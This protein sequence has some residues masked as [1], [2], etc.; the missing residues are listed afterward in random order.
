MKWG[1]KNI[2]FYVEIAFACTICKMSAIVDRS[3]GVTWFQML[4]YVLTIFFPLGASRTS[5]QRQSQS[6]QHNRN[7][8]TNSGG[9]SLSGGKKV[10]CRCVVLTFNFFGEYKAWIPPCGHSSVQWRHTGDMG[11]HITSYLTVFFQQLVQGN[12]KAP[13][14]APHH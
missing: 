13:T 5:L 8:N 10:L 14:K 4:I 7:R 2:I 11:Y 6:R 9:N 1:A 3:Q 12:N